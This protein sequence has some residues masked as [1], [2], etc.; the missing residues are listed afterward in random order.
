M[1]REMSF[2]YYPVQV[3]KIAISFLFK[4]FRK[5][6]KSDYYLCHICLSVC[7][8]KL[9]SH[10]TD[11]HEILYVNILQKYVDKILRLY[12]SPT[13]ITDTFHEDMFTFI[14][15]FRSIFLKIGHVSDKICWRNHNTILYP[16]TFFFP[17]IMPFMRQ[18]GEM[19]YSRTG[20]R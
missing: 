20:H 9:G 11:F 14:T 3:R 4:R 1:S 6:S 5:I 13:R 15:V 8:E 17:K 19:W 10:W 2:N 7:I 16:V 18:F 12:Y